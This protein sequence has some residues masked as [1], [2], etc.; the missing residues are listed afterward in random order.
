MV[1][2]KKNWKKEVSCKICGEKRLVRK[3]TY[4]EF[5][6]KCAAKNT[7]EK[8]KGKTW[9]KTK[10]CLGCKD[11]IK[12]NQR[13]DYCSV[14]C[15]I[16]HKQIQRVCKKCSCVFTIRKSAV[17]G[18]TNASGKFCSREC[19]HKFLCR[20]ERT[21]G[22]GSQWNKIRKSVLSKFPFCAVCGTTKNLQ[23][24][25]IIP[26][27]LTKDNREQNLIPLCTKHHKKQK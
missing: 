7:G 19:Y 24:H 9:A 4:P 26:F 6:K 23:V 16:K 1:F 20:T 18:K 25:H 10:K 12:D 11:K 3:D 2:S 27:R 15:R 17:S 8:L 13:Y 21:T 5:C 14:N 22:R